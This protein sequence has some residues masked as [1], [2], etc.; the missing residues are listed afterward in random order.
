MGPVGSVRS[1]P[2]PLDI[3]MIASDVREGRAAPCDARRLLETFNDL[4]DHDVAQPRELLLYLR[5]SFRRYLDNGKR[6]MESAL[7]LKRRKGR[8]KASETRQIQI[9]TDVL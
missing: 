9:A 4:V 8:P 2:N 6:G 7:G 3:D 5:D 1:R